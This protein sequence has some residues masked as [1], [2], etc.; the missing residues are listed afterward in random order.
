MNNYNYDKCK[1]WASDP[2]ISNQTK[3]N[4]SIIRDEIPGYLCI[5]D[6]IQGDKFIVDG[7]FSTDE[8]IFI[9]KT[10]HQARQEIA[11]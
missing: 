5:A 7:W 6:A 9:G 1:N 4:L 10:I 2:K 11:K 8:L 3:I